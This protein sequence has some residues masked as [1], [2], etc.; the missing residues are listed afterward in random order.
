MSITIRETFT[1]DGAL[2]NVTSVVL[3]DPTATF[4]VKRNDTDGVVVADGTALTNSSTGVYEHTFDQPAAGLTYTYWVEWVYGGET[5]RYE[6][7]ISGVAGSDEGRICTLAD[8]KER[9]G[10]A[11]TD[12]DDTLIRLIL[13]CEGLFN[14]FVG[15]EL[16]QPAADV[17]EYYTGCGDHLQLKRYPIIAITSIK[18]ALD[19]DF[20]SADALVAD[21]AYRILNDGVNGILFRIYGAWFDT[22]DATQVIYRGGYCAVS[23]SPGD[24]ETALPDDIRE[25]AIEQAGFLFK[26]RDDLGLSAISF[27]GGS[28]SKFSAIDLLPMVKKTLDR[29]RIPSL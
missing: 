9:L 11:N 13:S 25:A 24:G 1:I 18:E 10:L 23:E 20:A 4:G 19:Y 12:H 5:Y 6:G 26:R 8:V 17:T 27:E 2:T 28:I 7:S 16:L 15:R 14:T 22:P 3:S 21:E 29:Y